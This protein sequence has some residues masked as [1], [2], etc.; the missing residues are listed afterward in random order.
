MVDFTQTATVN[1]AFRELA[2][3]IDSMAAFTSIIVDILTNN[4]WGSKSYEQTGITLPR[5][6]K[7]S[8]SYAVRVIYENN[9]AKTVGTISIKASTPSTYH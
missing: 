7:A 4:P 9:V 6:S 8:E 3:S 5:V 1:T 2:A